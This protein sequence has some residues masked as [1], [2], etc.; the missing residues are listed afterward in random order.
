MKRSNGEGTWKVRE[1]NGVKTYEFRICYMGK[2]YSFYG[3][4]KSEAL[5]KYKN[6]KELWAVGIRDGSEGSQTL[7]EYAHEWLFD[8]KKKRIKV[9]TFDYYDFIIERFIKDSTPGGLTLNQLKKLNRKQSEKLFQNLLND[10]VDKSKSTLDGIYTVL[11]QVGKYG[12]KYGDFVYNFMECVTKISEKE[13]KTKKKE[14]KALKYEEVMKLWDEMLRKNEEGDIINNKAGTYVYG[15]GS[16]ALLFCCFTG[17]RWGEVSSL[18]WRDIQE[19]D[20][21]YFFKVDK[22]FVNIINRDKN[23]ETKH[24]TVAETP[25]SEKSCRYIP[26]SRRAVEILELVRERFPHLHK[27]GNLIFSNT[28]RPITASFAGK[29]LKAMCIR[30][31]VPVTS[32]HGLRHSFA[33]I[34]LNEDEK[35]LYEVSDML[36]HSSPDVT[37]KKYIDIFEKG[38]METISLFDKLDKRKKDD[39][40]ND[41]KDGDQKR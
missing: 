36:G 13:V 11:N 3:R 14:I 39:D 8:Y 1:R 28:G 15:I 17:L 2:R 10:N 6:D 38:K 4:T 25:K 7:Y 9:K 40:E 27:P 21:C 32:P 33:S 18:E 5:E 24:K 23:A 20:G 16:C 31:G 30:A 34:L 26:L 35:N 12:L 29:L 41:H 22:Q 19:N 37:Y